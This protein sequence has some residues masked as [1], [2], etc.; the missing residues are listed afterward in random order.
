MK[1]GLVG[2]GIIREYF[3]QNK[4]KHMQVDLIF[5]SK[6]QWCLAEIKYQ[7]SFKAPPFNG[8]GLPPWQ[9]NDRILFHNETGI[10]PY[11]FIVDKEDKIIYYLLAFSSRA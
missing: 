11:L 9:I 10:V 6:N 4:I 8:H 5:K 3:K 7:E 1:E 2:E